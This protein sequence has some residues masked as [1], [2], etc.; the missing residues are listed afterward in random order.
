[1]TKMTKSVTFH[2]FAHKNTQFPIN[3]GLFKAPTQDAE[4]IIRSLNNLQKGT[5][6]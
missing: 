4:L 5:R 2:T 3:L 6:L 1:M